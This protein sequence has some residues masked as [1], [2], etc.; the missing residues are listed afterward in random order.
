MG[1]S[2]DYV[3]DAE[4]GAFLS[5][6]STVE[7]APIRAV[8]ITAAS[9]VIDQATNRQFGSVDEPEA[10]LFTAHWDRRRRAYVVRIDDLSTDTGVAVTVDDETVTEFTLK[11]DRI[12][13]PFTTLVFGTGYGNATIDAVSVYGTWGWAAVPAAIE[14]ATLL[15]AHRFVMR[16]S[17]PLGVAGSP[18]LG[19]ELRLLERIDPDVRVIVTPYIRLWGAA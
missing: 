8:A 4:L 9:R 7:T 2:P 5:S 17:S 19:N 12:G 11:R 6:P 3:T 13:H 18:D 14:Q 10:R 1:W 15:Q 16:Q